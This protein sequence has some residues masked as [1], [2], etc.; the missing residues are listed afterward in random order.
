MLDMLTEINLDDLASA[1]GW[2][3]SPA[4]RRALSLSFRGLARK[5]ARQMLA[6]D[7]LVARFGL[8]EGAR[9]AL[10]GYVRG[11]R[12][13]GRDRLPPS[14]P[15]LVLSNHPGMSD[16]LCLFAAIGRPDLAV[17]AL[18]RPFLQALP[19]TSRHLVFLDEEPS[20]RM[21]AVRRAAA[22][23]RGG[24]ALLTFPA[25]EIEPDPDVYP[26]AQEAL[27]GWTDSTGVFARFVPELSIV[28]ALVR[29][30]L[31]DRAV[32]HPLTRLKAGRPDRERLGASFQLLAQLLFDLK[33]V[34]VRVEFA[35]PIDLREIGSAATAAI[36]QAVLERMRSLLASP[37]EG[38]G[39][40][41]L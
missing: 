29:S 15:V 8:A 32:R 11:L 39:T 34:T 12:V 20:Q 25:G 7:G 33:P 1:F 5:F 38:P 36:Q 24:G 19:A 3:A 2:Q 26:G 37:A 35:R 18:R 28:P 14:G 27:A 31:W 22:H 10:P 16:T 40:E 6:Y 4:L 21:G 17:I 41:V 9:R 23:L 30:V 13:D